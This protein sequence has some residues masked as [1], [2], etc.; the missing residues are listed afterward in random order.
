MKNKR[1]AS[2]IA[3]AV[4]VLTA[5]CAKQQASAF[6]KSEAGLR[7]L[8]SSGRMYQPQG[9]VSNLV[10]FLDFDHG[11]IAYKGG[12][13]AHV[14]EFDNGQLVEGHFGKGY[15]FEPSVNNLLSFNL[16]SAEEGTNGF[17]VEGGARI[18]TE[19]T[20]K[21][22]AWGKRFLRVVLPNNRAIITVP[23]E[24]PVARD[25]VGR[26]IASL[27]VRGAAGSKIGLSMASNPLA[28][29]NVHEQKVVLSN[30]WRRASCFLPVDG[31][32][33][34]PIS[35]AL[36][37]RNIGAEPVE[38]DLD[39]LQIEKVDANDAGRTEPARWVP[40][41]TFR[42]KDVLDVAGHKIPFSSQEG[43]MALWVKVEPPAAG[44]S[45]GQHYLI[46]VGSTWGKPEW[47]IS[48]RAFTAGFSASK[49]YQE[50]IIGNGDHIS[51]ALADGKWHHL[52]LTWNEKELAGFLDGKE[53][54]RKPIVAT[55][56]LDGAWLL[57]G[58]TPT[59]PNPPVS[60][61]AVLDDIMIYS[62]CFTP[63]E[64]QNLKDLK[65]P[66]GALL[67]LTLLDGPS[68]VFFTRNETEA[69]LSFKP[70]SWN[71]SG[72]KVTVAGTMP[73]ERAFIEPYSGMYRVCFKPCRLIPGAYPL[74]L[75][76]DDGSR[77]VSNTFNIEVAPAPANTNF[78]I[79]AWDG[80]ENAQ[81]LGFNAR[82]GYSSADI[83]GFARKGLFTV[84][85]VDTDRDCYHPMDPDVLDRSRAEVSRIARDVGCYPQV[86]ACLINTELGCWKAPVD[87]PWFDKWLKKETGLNADTPCVQN[88]PRYSYKPQST[89]GVVPDDD[90]A[91]RFHR[92]W[93][94][95]GYGWGE[96]NAEMR[97]VMENEGL[98]TMY[99][100]DRYQSPEAVKK[101]NL[102][103]DWKYPQT[104]E[105]LVAFWSWLRSRAMLADRGLL[106]TPGNVYWDDG[107]ATMVTNAEGKKVVLCLPPG[108][109]REYLWLTL[110][111]PIWGISFYGLSRRKNEYYDQRCDDV[112]R[113]FFAVA[114]AIGSMLKDVPR[115]QNDVAM[116][117]TSSLAAMD[118]EI[119]KWFSYWNMKFFSTALARARVDYDWI[120]E[121]HVSAGWLEKYKFVIVPFGRYL[122]ENIHKALC[123][124]A[125]AGGQVIADE[126]LAAD[127]P[128]VRKLPYRFLKEGGPEGGPPMWKQETKAALD[129]GAEYHASQDCDVTVSN[130]METWLVERVIDNVRYLFIINDKFVPGEIAER[131]KIK[132]NVDG[133]SQLIRDEGVAQEVEVSAHFPG[134]SAVYDILE[135]KNVRPDRA[136]GKLKWKSPLAPGGAKVYAI[137][138]EEINDIRIVSPKEVALGECVQIN[139][140]IPLKSGKPAPGRQLLEVEVTD[141]AG[142]RLDINQFWPIRNGD[143]IITFW[144]PRNA[145][146]GEWRM[147]LKEWTT[148][149]SFSRTILADPGPSSA[150]R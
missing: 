111:E 45:W 37:I 104:P 118:A 105:G 148:G 110:A 137:Y 36:K 98:R 97:K 28:S 99:C 10:F 57:I 42:D 69:E 52:A 106:P 109:L 32:E 7:E 100:S 112:M 39:G 124:F 2:F 147:S 89:N 41:G 108:R 26:Y 136:N 9:M 113:E 72:G 134:D 15:R 84:L 79:E 81:S 93:M 95:H 80:G 116:L 58:R 76:L 62:R 78:I 67:P 64:I 143:G 14:L 120:T 25:Y 53:T 68:R 23:V 73:A 91:Y 59:P 101:M 140:S 85:R 63:G 31:K 60:A 12:A 4:V 24:K 87:K 49:G 47:A 142:K 27:Y 132:F 21:R 130:P 94:A 144:I 77:V 34:E 46:G 1:W 131:F 30:V 145:Q 66:I 83:I 54:G 146:A 51:G 43:T 16:S 22:R 129:W 74:T 70:V 35:I 119:Y 13:L 55:S 3:L 75:A 88:N 121:E 56:E 6:E 114:P 115:R 29:T 86:A 65:E 33:K 71:R 19:S 20:E 125:E 92:W 122:P 82:I 102:V 150:G 90:P 127:V 17:Q 139:I 38:M 126:M 135:H 133:E 128:G 107:N 11:G 61:K 40:G 44:G 18:S 103:S 8:L 96:H 5:G 138:P 48:T 141:P 123:E 149:Q 117:E 50:S